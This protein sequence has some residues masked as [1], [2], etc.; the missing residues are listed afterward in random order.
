M[1][2]NNK[3]D[4]WNLD[5]YIKKPARHTPQKPFSPSATSA[6]EVSSDVKINNNSNF[7]DSP[8]SHE[9][10]DNGQI[11]RFIPPY[12]KM[13]TAKKYVLF[14]YTPKNPLIKSIKIVSKN[15]NDTSFVD[16]NLFMRERKAILSR[17]SEK[18][19]HTSFYSFAPRYSQMSR[20][21][22]NWYVWW[23]ENARNGIFL[24]TDESYVILFAYELAATGDDEDKEKAL[25]L[26]CSL[27]RE[28]S[29][30]RAKNPFYKLIIRDIIMDFCILHG[31]SAPVTQLSS[32]LKMLLASATIPEFFIDLSKE[33]A[34]D[35]I[36]KFL[37][38][39]SMYDFRRSKFYTP[40][41]AELFNTAIC[42]AVSAVFGN[43]EAYSSLLSFANGIYGCVTLEHKLFTR[44][45]NIVNKSITAEITYFQLSNIQSAVTDAIRYSENKLRE[46][47]GVKNKL[48]V[49]SLSPAVR[50]AIDYYFEA[51]YPAMSIPDRRRKTEK[52]KEEEF[53]EYD[54]FYDVP[55]AEISP[56]K[57]LEIEMESWQTTKILTEAFSDIEEDNISPE[58]QA[59]HI[60]AKAAPIIPET[61]ETSIAETQAE[62]SGNSF[63]SQIYENIGKIAE[64]IQ[65][66]K[67]FPLTAQR[68]FATDNKLSLDEL[69]DRI[70]ESAVEIM[71]DILL[72]D[73]GDG[74]RIIDDY[75]DLV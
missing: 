30:C 34:R 58:P 29:I 2:D 6:V 72:E 32:D 66:C 68:K 55:K 56:E 69:A 60:E 24:E 75:K 22:L 37:S 61:N 27:F 20:A 13:A 33:N 53:H 17:K 70:N 35:S 15:E 39:M 26:L 16:T 74:Y 31:F 49:F 65:L 57:A 45:V 38:Y 73:N 1:S 41:N 21:Q 54:R 10:D 46:H 28:D 9:K 44:M 18:C 25:S 12:K 8:I 40:E 43:E 50:S 5:E 7:T 47:L 48:N 59:T 64:F 63:Y 19:E 42:E 14:E 62:V 67:T 11:T 52:Q 3:D 36:E 23:R 51:N 71:G 4:F